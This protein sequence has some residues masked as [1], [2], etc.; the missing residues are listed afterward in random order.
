[1]TKIMHGKVECSCGNLVEMDIY[2]SVNVTVS[3]E[4]KDK[5]IN[6]KIN[7]YECKNCGA[8]TELASHFLYVD[9]RKDH[10][11]YV[12][13]DARRSEKDNILAELNKE[14][15][16]AKKMS[17]S[18]NIPAPIVVFGYDELFEFIKIEVIK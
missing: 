2:N 1:M 16:P 15:E 8:K 4:L 12:Y 7:N 17:E 14:L 18:L 11:L 5:I 3:P 13:P 9:L 6:R 10:W